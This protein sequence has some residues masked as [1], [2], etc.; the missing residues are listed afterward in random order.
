[1][2]SARRSSSQSAGNP[3]KT[4]P[5]LKVILFSLLVI[6]LWFLHNQT[7]GIE[8]VL[9]LSHGQFMSTQNHQFYVFDNL[10]DASAERL[11]ESIKESDWSSVQALNAHGYGVKRIVLLFALCYA[12]VYMASKFLLAMSLGPFKPRLP[13]L[14]RQTWR[15]GLL[16]LGGYAK[17]RGFP[18]VL[19]YFFTLL[20]LLLVLKLGRAEP[21]AQTVARSLRSLSC[22]RVFWAGALLHLLFFEAVGPPTPSSLRMALLGLGLTLFVSRLSY[23]SERWTT[24]PGDRE[25]LNEECRFT[26]RLGSY[27]FVGLLALIY[28]ASQFQLGMASVVVAM[29]SYLWGGFT[30]SLL[31]RAVLKGRSAD[32]NMSRA[33]SPMR[34]AASV[35]FLVPLPFWEIFVY[36]GSLAFLIWLCALLPLCLAGRPWGSPFKK[37]SHRLRDALA[38]PSRSRVSKL[39]SVYPGV[40]EL[41]SLMSSTRAAAILFMSLPP[42]LSARLFSELGPEEVQSITLEITQL[43]TVS[44]ELRQDLCALLAFQLDGQV[45]DEPIAQLEASVRANPNRAGSLLYAWYLS[46]KADWSLAAHFPSSLEQS[47][48]KH[49]KKLRCDGSWLSP[50]QKAAVLFMSLPPEMSAQLF[51]E[52]GPEEVQAITLEI[53]QLPRISP[54]MREAVLREFMDS[55]CGPPVVGIVAIPHRKPTEE[56]S[57]VAGLPSPPSVV[58]ERPS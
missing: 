39:E 50:K 29:S 14:N 27:D 17:H 49:L 54:E 32:P 47:I 9:G 5:F 24:F 6:S 25:T 45:G 10:D 23:P 34:I 22:L 16:L 30:L 1:M 53:T 19:P 31:L 4:P 33:A 11:T 41:S 28:L 48:S 35:W 58:E 18:D 42:E 56:P 2:S 55:G 13:K 37:D 8:R 46:S 57:P 26:Y 52:L 12:S 38:G 20:G 36:G 21:S 7:Q 40:K 3:K 44:P 51:S 43:P 15:F